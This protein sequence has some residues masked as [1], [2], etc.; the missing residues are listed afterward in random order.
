MYE[1]HCTIVQLLNCKIFLTKTYRVVKKERKYFYSFLLK[2][3]RTMEIFRWSSGLLHL[4]YDYKISMRLA[5]LFFEFYYY[6]DVSELNSIKLNLLANFSQQKKTTSKSRKK[7]WVLGRVIKFYSL[8]CS[9]LSLL[10]SFAELLAF[11]S[12]FI[13]FQFY[14]L[15]SLW[16]ILAY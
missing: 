13:D 2:R 4:Q 14:L 7:K 5:W 8:K 11:S 3:Q 15:S 12:F 6:Y 1:L 9:L 10:S 16:R